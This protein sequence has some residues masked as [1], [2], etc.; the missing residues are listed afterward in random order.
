MCREFSCTSRNCLKIWW[1]LP[2][3]W[4]NGGLWANQE[5]KECLKFYMG[6]IILVTKIGYYVVINYYK[7]Y[8][9]KMNC[10]CFWSFSRHS[11]EKLVNFLQHV[12][13][14]WNNLCSFGVWANSAF[15]HLKKNRNSSYSTMSNKFK[16]HHII[17]IYWWSKLKELVIFLFDM[18]MKIIWVAIW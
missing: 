13:N 7:H 1:C 18:L 15:Q 8:Q 6:S 14:M 11:F 12:T 9:H 3:F 10:V 5:K 17:K 2:I 16:L 4:C